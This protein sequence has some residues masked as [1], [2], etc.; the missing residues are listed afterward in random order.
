MFLIHPKKEL[1]SEP[2]TLKESQSDPQQV[3]RFRKGVSGQNVGLSFLFS[4]YT[5]KEYPKNLKAKLD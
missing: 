4:V 5:P 1:N 3:I 2:D